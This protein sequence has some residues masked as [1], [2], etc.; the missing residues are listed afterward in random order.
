LHGGQGDAEAVGDLAQG[1]AGTDG[2][3]HLAAALGGIGFLHM[4]VSSTE[5][6]LPC[7]A[8]S[9]GSRAEGDRRADGSQPTESCL[10]LTDRGV[11]ATIL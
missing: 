4:A 11:R 5:S 6:F 7:Y 9:T 1:S 8:R 3:D 10:R 2:F